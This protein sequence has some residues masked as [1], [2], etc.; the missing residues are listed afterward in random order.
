M[1][2]VAVWQ[3]AADTEGRLGVGVFQD[4][5]AA[6][7]AERQLEAR[8]TAHVLRGPVVADYRSNSSSR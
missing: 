8:L 2:T 1:K 7:A 6:A 5:P 3:H 4:G